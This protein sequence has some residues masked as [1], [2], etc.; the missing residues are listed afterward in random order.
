MRKAAI[1]ILMAVLLGGCGSTHPKRYFQV[2]T[3]A[4]EEPALPKVDRRVLVEPSSV[5]P[6]YDDVR[7]LYRVSP[8]ELK[9]YPYEFWAEKPGKQ[10]GDAM[11]QLLTTKKVFLSVS[12]G[13]AGTAKE[14][15]EIVLRSHVR[16]IEEIDTPGPWWQARLAADL[17]FLDFKAG[18]AVVS[19]SFDRTERMGK[20][21]GDLPAVLSRI[22]DEELG[23]A[24]WEL[25]RALEKK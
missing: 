11:A 8:Y 21:V 1:S 19:S 23:K 14:E 22:L 10:I 7:I 20:Q 12:Q 24:V 6:L 25:A 17:E 2:R 5:D 15:P 9:Y 16:I 4:A 18:R 13:R 3:I